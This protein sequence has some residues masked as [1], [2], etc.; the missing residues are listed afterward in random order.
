MRARFTN[1]S[2]D[3]TKESKATGLVQSSAN[4]KPSKVTYENT[5]VSNNAVAKNES[6]DDDD[7]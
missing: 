6:D 1:K 7:T 5:F 2:S 4:V 3:V